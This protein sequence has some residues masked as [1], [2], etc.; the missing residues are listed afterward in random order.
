M[1]NNRVVMY[2]IYILQF[3]NNKI[4]I[5]ID[6]K[7]MNLCFDSNKPIKQKKVYCSLKQLSNAKAEKCYSNFN[8]NF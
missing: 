1:S 5:D 6:L 2:L 3:Y 4:V 7:L 8:G